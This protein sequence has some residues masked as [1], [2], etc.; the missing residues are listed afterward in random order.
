[1]TLVIDEEL[2]C[3]CEKTTSRLHL[4]FVHRIKK[5]RKR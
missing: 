3:V 1:M 4:G 5:R 2:S